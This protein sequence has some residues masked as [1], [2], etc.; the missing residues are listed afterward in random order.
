[1]KTFCLTFLVLLFCS[2]PQKT[3]AQITVDY[4]ATNCA[5]DS[6]SYT[7]E[8]YMDYSY[9][10]LETLRHFT[11]EQIKRIFGESLS[12]KL[13]DT[14]NEHLDMGP[15]NFKGGSAELSPAAL[16]E[17]NKVVQFMAQ[18]GSATISIEGHA[19]Y[20]NQHAQGLSEKRANAALM[21]LKSMGIP[22]DRMKAVGFGASKPLVVH[23]KRSKTTANRRIEIITQ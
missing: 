4:I 20:H 6:G 7:K 13:P 1:M 10:L 12:V 2:L 9:K 3:H 14:L 18:N 8:D 5:Y 21:Y 15:V 11:P 19:W 16:A 22:E 23:K 17:L